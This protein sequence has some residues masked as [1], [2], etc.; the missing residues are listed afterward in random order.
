VK[1]GNRNVETGGR[2]TDAP[3]SDDRPVDE[4]TIPTR[5]VTDGGRDEGT[6][7][8]A[9]L[10]DTPFD[11]AVV[12]SVAAD[13]GV[14]MEGL[15]DALVV[16]DASL[17]GSHSIY[18]REYEYATVK[19]VRVY[20]VDAAAWESLREAHDLDGAL[21]DAARRAHAD[22]ARDLLA[23]TDAALSLGDGAAIVVGIDTAEV[24]N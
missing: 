24:M 22:Q 16:L 10:N 13:A 20:A 6:G 18:E 7:E 8:A 12:E 3:M 4:T 15:V 17:I 14:P 1:N 21:L 23:P 11:P 2:R 19:G 5:P 9:E